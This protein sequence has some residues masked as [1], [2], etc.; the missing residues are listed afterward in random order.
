MCIVTGSGNKD[1]NKKGAY[2]KPC[3]PSRLQ[4]DKDVPASEEEYKGQ[5]S[6]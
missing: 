3:R 5:N 1:Q 2:R 6:L 4:F